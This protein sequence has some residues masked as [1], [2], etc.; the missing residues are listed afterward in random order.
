MTMIISVVFLTKKGDAYTNKCGCPPSS[1]TCS[2]P[3]KL[4]VQCY[5]T[6]ESYFMSRTEKTC[7][8]WQINALEPLTYPTTLQPLGKVYI[9]DSKEVDATKPTLLSQGYCPLASIVATKGALRIYSRF[10]SECYSRSYLCSST[11]R[12]SRCKHY[13]PCASSFWSRRNVSAE[14]STVCSTV[15]LLCRA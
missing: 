2:S 9:T 4:P 3:P 13:Y 12:T 10:S 1:T 6:E 11:F 15:S 7:L 5:C 8:H 14:L